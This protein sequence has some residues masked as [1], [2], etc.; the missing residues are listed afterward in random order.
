MTE[1]NND[2]WDGT[3]SVTFGVFG[4]QVKLTIDQTPF[5]NS[6]ITI[7]MRLI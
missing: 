3:V 2:D 6:G 5:R 7:A 4:T 1:D